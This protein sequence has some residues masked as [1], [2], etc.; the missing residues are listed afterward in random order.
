M[1]KIAYTG[2]NR[3]WQPR[4]IKFSGRLEKNA[5]DPLVKG[6]DCSIGAL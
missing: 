2:S 6:K 4:F 5:V 3:Q 1:K